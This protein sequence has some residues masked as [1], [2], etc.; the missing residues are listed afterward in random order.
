MRGGTLYRNTVIISTQYGDIDGDSKIEKVTLVGIPYEENEPYMEELQLIIEKEDKSKE[1]FN[2][3][4]GGYSF[5]LF[6]GN[7]IQGKS[8]QILITGQSG[9]SGMYAVTRLYKYKNKRL[10]LIFNDEVLSSKLIC[11]A[12]YLKGFKVEVICKEANKKHIID[13]KNNSQENLA[14]IYDN[15][16]NI[17]SNIEPSV[18]G[19][20]SIYPIMIPYSDYYSLQIQQRIIGV[21]NADNL[22][23][24]QTI[25]NIDTSD[26]ID[27]LVQSLLIL[28]EN[29]E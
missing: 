16:G 12:R 22:G 6:L 3:K 8:D 25:I 7:I 4:A 17:I 19:V 9:G 11:Y 23:V 28:G 5:N 27:I 14:P 24:I 15:Q 20:N 1:F 10:K 29:I 18:S 2:I 21:N 13:I 26:N